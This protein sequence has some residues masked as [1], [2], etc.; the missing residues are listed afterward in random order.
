MFSE[1]HFDEAISWLCDVKHDH[2][3]HQLEVSV[4]REEWGATQLYKQLT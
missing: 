4:T 3:F 2:V 1:Y